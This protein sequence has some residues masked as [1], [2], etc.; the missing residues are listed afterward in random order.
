M[1]KYFV[2][3]FSLVMFLSACGT[4]VKVR[5]TEAAQKYIETISGFTCRKASITDANMLIIAID[6]IGSTNYYALASQFLD[7]AKRE[8]VV[9]L[10][11]CF[12]VNFSTSQFQDGA[13]IGERIGEAFN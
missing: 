11:G 3:A 8:G 5:E 2:L 13:V 1:K 9:G 6:A 10:K 4:K 7:D 12:V